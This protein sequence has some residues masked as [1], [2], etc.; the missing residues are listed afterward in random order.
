MTR[1]EFEILKKNFKAGKAKEIYVKPFQN[2]IREYFYK[3][4]PFSDWRKEWK[5]RDGVRL[6]CASHS[7]HTRKTLFFSRMMECYCDKEWEIK[8]VDGDNVLL[9]QLLDDGKP[10]KEWF[11]NFAWIEERKPYTN[12]KELRKAQE[13]SKK[14]VIN[15]ERLI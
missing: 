3:E 5:L 6:T 13:R 11:F 10:D 4:G 1:K 12:L 8:D 14:I 2:L 9:A 15:D 7:N